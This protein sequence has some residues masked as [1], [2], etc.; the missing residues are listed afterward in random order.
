[1]LTQQLQ[2]GG[3]PTFIAR[4]VLAATLGA[5]YGIYG[6]AFELCENVA[7]EPGSEEDLNSEKNEIRNWYL[8][9][10]GSLGDLLARINQIRR[11]NPALQRDDSLRFHEIDNEMMIAYSKQA[12]NRSLTPALSPGGG[13]GEPSARVEN[14]ILV[15]V[16]LDPHH[17]QRGW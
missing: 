7:R 16:N 1:I 12:V 15:I 17:L 3:H 2:Y 11:D 4:L 6:P 5:S 14:I 13:E 10:P 9:A 8:N